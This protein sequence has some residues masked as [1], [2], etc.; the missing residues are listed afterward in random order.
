M[1]DLSGK[2]AIV[3]GAG[4]G[5]GREH[6]LALARAG[7]R[8]VVNDRGVS[9][10]G[11][12]ADETPAR[13][14]VQEIEALGSEAVA[15]GDNVADF[16]GAKQ[17]VDQA[18]ET[19]GR[20]DILVNNAG[21]L[22][23]RM[24]VN[25][26]EDEWDAVIAVHLKGH[27]AP[28]RHAAS[29]W[30]DRSKAGEEVRA[31]VVNT[32]SPSG[33][34]GN[35]G[36]ANYGAAKAGRE[37]RGDYP[38]LWF[39]G[40]WHRSGDLFECGTRLAAGLAEAGVAPGERVVVLMENS[41]DVPVVYH[42]V[43]RAGGVV[44]PVIF[45]TPAEE[46]RRIVADCEPALVLTSP[47]FADTVAAATDGGIRVI[48]SPEELDELA[49][50]DPAPIVPRADDDLTAL[51]YTGG[52]TGHSKGVMLTHAN[53]WEAGRRGQEAGH[54]EGISRSLSC[55][56]LSHVYGLL[57]LNVGM[58]EPKRH[59]SVLMRWFDAE[60]WLALAQEHRSQIAPLVPS[61]IG[62]LLAQP[63]EDFD[64]SELRY[65]ASGAAPLA[66]EWLRALSERL[67]H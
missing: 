60:T 65:I 40:A 8:V 7:A 9:V 13:Q 17:L 34:F 27:F 31:R 5:I 52:T 2:I 55:L 53:L 39:E 64:L 62:L 1:P 4:R 30:R 16:A 24:L 28:T 11:E 61:M 47:S 23:D 10:A 66:A 37:R 49:V 58:H 26:E 57:V 6:A 44:T 29:Y 38:A 21:I 48:S 59:E 19:F 18:L 46:L 36:Q 51:V 20:L 56:P 35:V 54:A 43:A 45:L 32:S 33:V 67:P 12:G 22:R 14:V 63:L 25:M 3:T 42:A 50:H 41:P 15:N